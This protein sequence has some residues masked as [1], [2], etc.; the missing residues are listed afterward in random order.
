MSNYAAI[1]APLSISGSRKSDGTANDSG[2]VY[3]YRPGTLTSVSLYAD[4]T[5][6]T[7]ATQ[8]IVLDVGGR[9]PVADY[10][11]GIFVTQP[12]RL[13]IQDADGVTVSD[14]DYVPGSAGAT[15]LSNAGWSGTTE[16]AAWTALYASLGGVDGKYKES[17]GATSRTIKAKFQEQGIWVEDFGAVGDGVQ[18]STTQIQGAMSRAVALGCKLLFGPGEF[19]IDQNITATSPSGVRV[20]GSGQGQTLIT[21]TNAA[22]GHFVL[23]SSTDCSVE[24]MTLE[25]ATAGTTSIAFNTTCTRPA[26]INVT[27]DDCAIAVAMT[28]TGQTHARIEGCYF[29]GSSAAVSLTGVTHGFLGVTQMNNLSGTALLLSGTTSAIYVGNCVFAATTGVQFNTGYTG[30]YITIIGCPQLGSNTTTA[31]DMSA[32]AVDPILRQWG[33]RVDG[34]T[35]NVLTG[36]TATPDRSRGPQIRIRGTSTGSAYTVAAPTPPPTSTMN[37]VY[38]K[39]DFFNDAGGAVT[40]WTMDAAYHL[41]AGPSTVNGEHT[42]YL[43]EWDPN[44]SVWRQISR[45]VTT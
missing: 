20:L 18:V 4:A 10:P 16:D 44:S 9:V 22:A 11:D 28:D 1:L 42:T 30:T 37:E 14:L 32:L 31:I 6:E 12:V 33:N 39:L 15:G 8:P 34:Y 2:L 21:Q 25:H 29:T 23:T 17:G 7:I 26:V 40:G 36:A 24:E 41:S 45:S 27:S 19:I 43:L 38:L 3:A 35:V 13:V 5:A